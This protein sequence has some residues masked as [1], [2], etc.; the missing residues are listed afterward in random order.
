VPPNIKE[1][2]EILVQAAQQ[3][4]LPRFTGASFHHK[5]R[6]KLDGSIVTVADFEMQRYMQKQL[7]KRWPEYRFLGEEMFEHEQREL[8][9]DHTTGLWCLDPLDGTSNFAAGIPFF[10]VSLALIIGGVVVIGLVYDPVR[11]EFFTAQKGQGAWLNDKRL[12]NRPVSPLL[13]Q[14]IAVVDFKRLATPLA[15]KLVAHPPYY[16]QRNFGSVVLEWCWLAA[17]RFHVYLHGRQ[18]LWDYAAGSLILH[19]AGGQTMTLEG[20]KVGDGLQACSAVA[21]LDSVLFEEW[22]NWIQANN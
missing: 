11:N 8:M 17:S 4:L 1:L 7:E 6:H 12:K 15:T 16:S 22:K 5:H 3:E 13:G 14:C 9:A 10:A 21:A 18:K 2:Q 19:E 20:N